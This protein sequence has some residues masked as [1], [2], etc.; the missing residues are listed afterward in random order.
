MQFMAE[1][2]RLKSASEKM[3]GLAAQYR[4]IYTQLYSE[5]RGMGT[6]W[7]GADNR[8]YIE[9]IN[10]FEQDLRDLAGLIEQYAELTGSAAAEYSKALVEATNAARQIG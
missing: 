3:K 9:Q 4:Q 5:V 1:I 8:K 7:Q 2:D 10:G 6:A